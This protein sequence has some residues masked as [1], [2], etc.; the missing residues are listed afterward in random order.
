MEPNIF[1]GFDV[2]YCTYNFDAI[3][4]KLFEHYSWN[5]RPNVDSISSM[6]ASHDVAVT[7]HIIDIKG[8]TFNHLT[9]SSK[10]TNYSLLWHTFTATINR[11]DKALLFPSSLL[12]LATI[13]TTSTAYDSPLGFSTRVLNYFNVESDSCVDPG[14][15]SLQRATVVNR[16]L[17]HGMAY[18][19]CPSF[20]HSL[21]NFRVMKA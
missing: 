17:V 14:I 13:H 12:S 11:T 8:G 16:F 21:K 20:C 10:T 7:H 4:G 2:T 18:V 1:K 5:C 9:W 15:A 3:L 6:E 19:F